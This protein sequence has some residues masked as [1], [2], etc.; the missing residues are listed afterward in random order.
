MKGCLNLSMKLCGRQPP[1]LEKT[2]MNDETTNTEQSRVA[3][4]CPNERLVI[5]QRILEAKPRMEPFR[6]GGFINKDCDMARISIDL[7]IIEA[8]RLMAALKAI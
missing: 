2:T 4:D 3:A 5:L 1:A 6:S 7:P 8:K